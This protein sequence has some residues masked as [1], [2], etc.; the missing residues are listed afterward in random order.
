MFYLPIII[1]ILGTTFYHVGQ[2]SIP[3]H[4]SPVLSLAVN[5]VTALVATLLLLPLYPLRTTGSGALP[6]V[7]WASYIVGISIV[8]V[9]LAVLL[10]YRT[11]WK[12]SLVSVRQ[13]CERVASSFYRP[14][15]LSRAAIRKECRRDRVVPGWSGIDHQALNLRTPRTP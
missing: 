4:L 15:F 9:E 11:G 7:N 12:I 2:K 10:A 14:D 8:G 13:Y 5:Y 3:S 6:S 1:M